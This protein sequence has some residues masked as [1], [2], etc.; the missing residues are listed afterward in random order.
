MIDI[1][2]IQPPALKPAEPPLALAVLLAHLR[3]QKITCSAIDANLEAYRYLLDN[4]RLPPGSVTRPDTNLQRA[5]KHREASLRLLQG[6]SDSVDFARYNTAVRYLNRL[7][8]VWNSPH[9]KVTL[10]DYQHSA[11]SPFVPEDLNRLVTGLEKTLFTSYFTQH[12]L[13]QVQRAQPRI[14]GLSINYLHQALPAFELAGILRRACP[15]IQLVAGGGLI[16]S[17]KETLKQLDLQLPP[18]DR[19]IF[20]PAEAA[21]TALV[22]ETEKLPAS[23]SDHTTISFV[24]DFS[25]ARIGEYLS[26]QPILPLTASRGCYWRQCL[27][28]PEAASPVHPYCSFPQAQLPREMRRLA[29]EHGIRYI[30]LTDNAIPVNMLRA[31]ADSPQE[32]QDINWFGFVRF[33]KA[34]ED[35]DFVAKLAQS[36]CRMLQLGLE[37]GSQQVLDRLQKGIRLEA[38]E[39]ILENLAA[40][41]IA[42]F[43]YIMLGTPGETEADA[44]L[45]LGFLEKHADKI[46]FLNISIMNMPRA[47]GLLDNPEQYGIGDTDTI[48]SKTPLALYQRFNSNSSWNRATARRFLNQRLLGSVKI[49]TIVNRTPPLFTSNHAVFFAADVIPLKTEQNRE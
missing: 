47:S 48:A 38:V 6:G 26:P 1:L 24:P 40:A 2:L 28:C 3:A 30:Q 20:G 46:G 14:I 12:L 27:F 44:E 16:T 49:R 35:P 39:R 17:W 5:I 25:F 11:L 32:M 13:P 23:S 4:T 33:E 41:G 34:L 42:T 8:A 31:L 19:L 7:L 43:V 21:L 36:G 22:K 15:H 29:D 18:F 10:G 37:S 45:T 9:E